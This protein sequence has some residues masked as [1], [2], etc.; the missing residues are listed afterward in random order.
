M[1]WESI[2]G[3]AGFAHNLHIY[4]RNNT[5]QGSQSGTQILF[6]HGAPVSQRAIARL[7]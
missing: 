3:S 4:L 2:S 1:K 6:S 5:S 7:R